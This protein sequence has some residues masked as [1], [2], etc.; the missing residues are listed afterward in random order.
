MHA[1]FCIPLK[2]DN[3]KKATLIAQEYKDEDK[4]SFNLYWKKLGKSVKDGWFI[5]HAKNKLKN[6]STE[7]K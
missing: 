2:V 4:K 7:K 3:L 1:Q 5:D 6:N